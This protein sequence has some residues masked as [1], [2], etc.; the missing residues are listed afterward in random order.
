MTDASAAGQGAMIRISAVIPTLNE[1]KNVGFVL[2]AIPSCVDEVIIVDGRS[3]DGTVDAARAVRPDVR[4]VRQVRRGKGNALAAGVQAARGE[5][6][7]LLDA[8]GS[9]DPDELHRFVE[10]LDQGAEYVKGSRFHRNGGSDDLTPTR[11]LGN[12]CLNGLTNV[13]FG[14]GFT[15]LC[16]G[17][18]ALR[19]DRAHVLGLPDP[20][21]PSRT[22]LWGDGF[23][24]ETLINIRAAKAGLVIVEVPSHEHRRLH[25]QSNLN[26]FR[27]GLRVLR[28]ILREHRN[29]RVRGAIDLRESRLEV[30]VPEGVTDSSAEAQVA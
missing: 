6:V 29:R 11:T 30:R 27:D 4:V 12:A 23:E 2:Q 21:L 8:D 5:Y 16:Y 7:V 24:V 9:M 20:R 18:N 28:T 1:A 22:P 17:Y 26:T 19:R 13:L 15:D 25:G 14:T 3:L 10:A